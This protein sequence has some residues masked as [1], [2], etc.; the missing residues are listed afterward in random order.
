M[1]RWSRDDAFVERWASARFGRGLMARLNTSRNNLQ[2]RVFADRL[3]I[4]PHFPFT[5]AFVPELYDLDKVIALRDVRSAVIQGGL[6][7]QLVEVVYTDA[8]GDEAVLLLLLRKA[9]AFVQAALRMK[10]AA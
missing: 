7:K 1:A 5:V 8:S 6:R 4:H 2:V 9:P 10:P 3:E